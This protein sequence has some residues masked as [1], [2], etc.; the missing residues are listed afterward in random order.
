LWGFFGF[1]RVFFGFWVSFLGL[2]GGFLGWGKA[3]S[4]WA[5]VWLMWAAGGGG[6][7]LGGEGG[8]ASLDT[9]PFL[10]KAKK[11]WGTHRFD[12]GG[13]LDV[14]EGFVFGFADHEEADEGEEG[15]GA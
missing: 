12:L 13:D 7:R 1:Y 10:G 8:L 9:P 3:G 14:G 15:G 11:G 2:E 6:L 4:L 5:K